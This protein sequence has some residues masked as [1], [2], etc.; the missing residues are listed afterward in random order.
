[1]IISKNENF[2][3]IFR[4]EDEGLV[5]NLD[6]T[7]IFAVKDIIHIEPYYKRVRKKG[8]DYIVRD[9]YHIHLSNNT[10]VWI[11]QDEYKQLI[12]FL[13]F[14]KSEIESKYLKD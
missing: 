4:K 7:E 10:N 5:G 1:M 8:E 11:N 13:S 12:E 14:N 3:M 2:V 9:G 6:Y